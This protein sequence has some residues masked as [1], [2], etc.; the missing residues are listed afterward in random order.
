MLTFNIRVLTY[1]AVVGDIA[2]AIWR[3]MEKINIEQTKKWDNSY[4]QVIKAKLA[5]TISAGE[6]MDEFPL[7]PRRIVCDTRSIVPDD[8]N[9]SVLSELS[10]T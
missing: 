1:R 5:A 3:I 7:D 6:K 8:G 2:N 10:H 4:Y 9:S